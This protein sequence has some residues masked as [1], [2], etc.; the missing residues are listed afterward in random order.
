MADLVQ[1]LVDDLHSG[2]VVARFDRAGFVFPL[3]GKPL[4]EDCALIIKLLTEH[5]VSHALVHKDSISTPPPADD[6]ASVIA[7]LHSYLNEKDTGVETDSE[8]VPRLIDIAHAIDMHKEA[9]QVTTNLMQEARLGKMID[10]AITKDTV[11]MMVEQCISSPEA[12]V[13]ITRLKDFDNYTFTHSVNVSVLAIALGKRLGF[14]TQ[15]L[16]DLG[17]AGLMHDIGKMQIPEE[18]LNKPGILTESEFDVMKQHSARGYQ[19]LKTTRQLSDDIL[20][21]V[22]YHHEKSDGSGY[23][24]GLHEAQIPKFAKII[25]IADVYDAITTARVYRKG[26]M[27]DEA[28]R[29]LFSWSGKHFNESLVRFFISVMGIYPAGTLVMLDTNELAIIIGPNKT[30]PVRPKV[31]VIAS[32]DMDEIEPFCFNLA[33][34]NAM[35]HKPYRSIVSAVDPA[36]FNI[37]INEK[38]ENYLNRG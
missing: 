33:S 38:I 28:I 37:N 12:F 15:E 11:S 14:S 30:D 24:D 34:Y 31:L 2:M 29:R 7:T 26:M 36:E 23:P 8:S 5:N 10:T 17:F 22:R 32:E 35:T 25:S 16:N 27:P 20:H 6:D 4:P 19:Y 13:S 9:T 21:A 18:I 1:V 3:Y